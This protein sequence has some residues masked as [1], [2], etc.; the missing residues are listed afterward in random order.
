MQEARQKNGSMCERPYTRR[1]SINKS[2]MRLAVILLEARAASCLVETS[3]RMASPY[4]ARNLVFVDD[5]ICDTMLEDGPD[6]L[7]SSMQ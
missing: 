7:M 4:K 6:E 5:A 1:I 2:M 3:G